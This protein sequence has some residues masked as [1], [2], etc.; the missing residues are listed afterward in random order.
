MI[1]GYFDLS[2]LPSEGDF[3]FKRKFYAINNKNT[4]SGKN[5]TRS[6]SVV[7]I[8]ERR[9]LTKHIAGNKNAFPKLMQ[10]YRRPIYSY[11]V[12]CGLNQATRDDL[13]QEI[14]LKVHKSAEQY[15]PTQP[16]SPW[17]FTIAVNTFRNYKREQSPEVITLEQSEE[18]HH[19]DPTPENIAHFTETLDWLEAAITKLPTDQ[20]EALTLASIHGL[21]LK[22]ISE[23]L[24][25]PVSTIKTH[26]RRA[27]QTL[28][29]SFDA[30]TETSQRSIS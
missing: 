23:I 19:S 18:L 6:E 30:I 1:L 16:L 28:I 4:L 21:K 10:A 15:N 14:F 12:R 29:R 5:M 24:E 2:P 11:L 26:I 27:R 25:R 20:A 7:D 13:F 8:E 9:W 22:E 3:D 17:I